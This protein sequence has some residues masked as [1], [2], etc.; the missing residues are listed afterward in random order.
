MENEIFEKLAVLEQAEKSDAKVK[1]ILTQIREL[2]TALLKGGI[3]AGK[4]AIEEIKKLDW[5]A[6]ARTVLI[7][8]VRRLIAK[9]LFAGI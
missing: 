4:K 2:I 9:V 8:I 7:E 5:R 3:E 1:T 6:E